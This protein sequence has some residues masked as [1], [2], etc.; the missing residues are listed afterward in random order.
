MQFHQNLSYCSLKVQT[1][2]LDFVSSATVPPEVN[3]WFKVLCHLQDIIT[4]PFLSCCRNNTTFPKLY[5][6]PSVGDE[7]GRNRRPLVRCEEK[8]S[9]CRTQ[10]KGTLSTLSDEDFVRYIF[11]NVYFS[12]NTKWLPNTWNRMILHCQNFLLSI[13]EEIILYQ[14]K[15]ADV[16]FV[17]VFTHVRKIDKSDH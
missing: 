8:S 11:W 6:L 16:N 13:K 17:T 14:H 3:W 10:L 7:A 2:F 1:I 9:L 15:S 12:L 5:L 4:L